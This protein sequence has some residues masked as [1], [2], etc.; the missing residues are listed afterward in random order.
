MN[1]L[2]LALFWGALFALGWLV[3]HALGFALLY[4]LP[5]AVVQGV[6]TGAVLAIWVHPE[7]TK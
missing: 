5:M 7:D 3:F 4:S 6:I 1:R 2:L